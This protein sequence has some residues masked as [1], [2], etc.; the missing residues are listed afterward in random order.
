[1]LYIYMLYIYA[2]IYI[3]IYIY[4][5]LNLILSCKDAYSMVNTLGSDANHVHGSISRV[6][7]TRDTMRI[8]G[9]PRR[10]FRASWWTCRWSTSGRHWKIT[11]TAVDVWVDVFFVDVWVDVFLLMF[12]L[13][14]HNRFFAFWIFLALLCS[15]K[16]MCDLATSSIANGQSVEVLCMRSTTFRARKAT[17]GHG[18]YGSDC[19]PRV[20]VSFRF[21][22]SFGGVKMSKVSIFFWSKWSWADPSFFALEQQLILRSSPKNVHPAIPMDKWVPFQLHW[23]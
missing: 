5:Y 15:Q 22:F 10:R 3:Y 4:T 21:F 17:L 1:M 12:G 11:A 13:I 2:Y 8:V 19:G 23:E 6:I 16:H 9:P 7:C 20:H 14:H 18:Q